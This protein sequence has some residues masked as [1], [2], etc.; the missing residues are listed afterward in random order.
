MNMYVFQFGWP[1]VQSLLL[2]NTIFNE[3]EKKKKTPQQKLSDFSNSEGNFNF[4][5]QHIFQEIAKPW[6][7]N[8]RG[9]CQV[10]VSALSIS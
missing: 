6:L 7:G 4:S 8:S 5:R 9:D 2:S 3:G 1:R 10:Y